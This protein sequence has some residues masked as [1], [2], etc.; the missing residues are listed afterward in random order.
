[1]TARTTRK[2]R[3]FVARLLPL[4]A[5]QFLG[6]FNDHAFKIIS[7]L[8]VM[9][10]SSSYS[11]DAI[12]LAFLTVVYVLPFILLPTPSGYLADRFK[13]KNVLVC[14]KTAELLVMLFGAYALYKFDTWG[15]WPLVGVM[16]L[17]ASQSA[18]FSPSFNALL[19]EVFPESEIS[20]ANGAVGLLSFIAVI[21]G[22]GLGVI[23]KGAAGDSLWVCGIVLSSISAVG[24]FT[25]LHAPSGKTPS[26]LKPW[27]W[28]PIPEAL[29]GFRLLRS[30]KSVLLAILGESYFLSIGTALQALLMIFAKYSLHL[31]NDADIGIVQLAPAI[32]IGIGCYL[33]GRL[34]SGKVEL[35][36]VP[37]GAVGLAVFMF[38]TIHFT[39]DAANIA[40]RVIYPNVIA[41]LFLLGIFGGIFV[42]PLRAYQQRYAKPETR[43]LLLANANLICFSMMMATGLIMLV[44][45]GG[46]KSSAAAHA[47]G[48]LPF[49]KE[50][51]LALDPGSIF[52]IISAL[53]LIVAIAAL[54]MIPDLALRFAALSLLQISY[55]LE[56]TGRENIPEN[57]PALL[58]SNHASFIDGFLISATSS[59]IIRFLIIEAF[60]NI[61]FVKR[62]FDWLG[63]IS[64]PEPNRPK[65]VK[66]AIR[67]VR[68]ALS[69]GELV[70]LFP[71]GG[72]TRNGIM[73]DFKKGYTL[74]IPKDRDVP[75][76]PIHMSGIWGSVF[77]HYF[78]SIKFRK[79]RKYPYPI[80]ITIGAPL[81]SDT[82]PEKLRQVI[83]EL[84]AEGAMRPER[85]EMP[86][87]A[88]FAKRA[89]RHP[90][91]KIVYNASSSNEDKK[92][93]DEDGVTNIALL[94]R[95]LLLSREIRELTSRKR[96]GILLPNSTAVAVTVLGA[97]FADKTAVI[98]NFTVSKDAMEASVA[99]GDID[100]ILTSKMFIHKAKIEKL[101]Q[102]IFLEDVAKG[103][104]GSA[105]FAVAAAAILA[106]SWLITR[107]F[108][109]ES[110]KNI[111][112]DALVIFSSGSSGD[113]KGIVLSHHNLN[114][115]VAAV[116]A[117]AAW[118]PR[119]DTILGNLPL[120]HSFGITTGFWLP[121]LTGTKVIYMP[122]PLD[123]PLTGKTVERHKIRIMLATPTFLQAYTRRCTK[124]QFA[125]LRLVI[126]GAE[127]LRP[128]IRVAFRK[129][130]GLEV[131]EGYGCTELSP[132]ASV[133]VPKNIKD[134]GREP[135]VEGSVGPA[136][137]GVA[138]KI[139]DQDTLEELPL[140]EEGILLIKGPNVMKGYLRGASE[141]KT[142]KRG[143]GETETGRNGDEE[144]LQS[145]ISNAQC[146]MGS[147]PQKKCGVEMPCCDPLVHQSPRPSV[148]LDNSHGDSGSAEKESENRI[149]DLD[150]IDWEL[151][152]SVIKDGWYNT[153]DMAKM[154][155]DGYISITGRLSR[156]SKI[157]GEMVPH[158]F[159]EQAI[160]EIISSDTRCHA[161]SSAPDAKKGEKL[162][163]LTTPEMKMEPSA[164]IAELRSNGD[165]PN[166]WIPKASDFIE[167]KKLPLLGS[168]KLDLKKLKAMAAELAG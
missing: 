35:G 50:W 156:F 147:F 34:S 42:I 11:N 125:S 12:F 107:I 32:G 100:L 13:K 104:S 89:K 128:N 67:K 61:P 124:E 49:L 47:G 56:I 130:T 60:Y 78:G 145:R 167:V 162:V 18:F 5:T 94:I 95:A 160:G 23:L 85:G 48:F 24:I 140:G 6:V 98:L 45:T 9:A 119:K 102:M 142:G 31:T 57:G 81:P 116:T 63:F 120:F 30:D 88:R 149:N 33:A 40:G 27:N 82:P 68:E 122:N 101:P 157:G 165:M 164:I 113:P 28:N 55:R 108:S 136:L 3:G 76:I 66:T 19:P 29:E 111:D 114:S 70:C 41:S 148:P 36:M 83:C 131:V 137:P 91:S 123:V 87:H 151:T 51:C 121:I 158:E 106:P 53:T 74:M 21:T 72:L 26:D 143:N 73:S 65:G 109:R 75:I 58:L 25:V 52:L 146:S 16:F 1:M 135:A 153:G 129:L 163:V 90:F 97:F 133:N 144:N 161:V 86:L 39:G 127:K 80:R 117:I 159:V 69:R 152:N 168:G 132:V 22:V 112:R 38:T 110:R 138:A 155:A 17:M 8:A 59:R 96:V 150:S 14:A 93:A 62:I 126:A 141:T 2:E 20:R 115:N 71:E 99:K 54:L 79:P 46:D 7:V 77:S 118:I 37:F 10:K 166:L 139:A 64:V 103:I 154:R 92:E 134:L 4:G 105:K 44:L 15:M 84:D 43:G